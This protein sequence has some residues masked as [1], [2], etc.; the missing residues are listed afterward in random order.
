MSK[1][2]CFVFF[3]LSLI[4]PVAAIASIE[5][6]LQG[7]E[8]VVID[9]IYHRDGLIYIP[10]DELLAAVEL[11]G[12]WDSIE[13]VY[14]I[15]S[16]RGTAVISPGSQ[17]LRIGEQ[18]IPL[19]KK[20]RF[21][22][23][24]LRVTESFVLKQLSNLVSSRLFYRN[25]T[26]VAPVKN[27]D[28][29]LD[30][31]FSFMLKKKKP[32]DAATLR[33]VG[34]DPGHGGY[35]PGS[36]GLGGIKEKDVNLSVALK[37]QK[38]VK[39]NLGVPVYLSRDD[40]YGMSL[41]EHLKPATEPDVDALL[42]LHSQSSFDSSPSGISLYIRNEE[43]STAGGESLRLANLLTDAL[44]EVGLT[45]HA[46]IEAPLLALGRGNLPTVLIEMGYLSHPE[47]NLLLS[48]EEGQ[49]RLATGLFNGLKEFGRESGKGVY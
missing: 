18:F 7:A 34:I 36:I 46:V 45:V 2:Y 43:S 38:I 44:R 10:I 40:D 24:K 42:L 28:S 27:D 48:T 41:E 17:F 13:H 22:D 23:N 30:R 15:S 29:T 14:R 39:M 37:L 25:L 16:D 5:V 8:P 3:I 32:V 21:I 19:Q 6:A 11:K 12:D 35:D 9:E 49:L 4:V 1:L 20:P 47:D 26:P 31:F 33:A